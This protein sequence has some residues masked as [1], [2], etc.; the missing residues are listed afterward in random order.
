MPFSFIYLVFV[1]QLRPLL[2]GAQVHKLDLRLM[3]AVLAE[4]RIE[5][6]R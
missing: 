1:S 6:I 5:S 4:T 2:G 3:R